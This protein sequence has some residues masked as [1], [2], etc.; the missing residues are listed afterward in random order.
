MLMI[1][2]AF[3]V[4]GED[5]FSQVLSELVL[6]DLTCSCS[7]MFIRFYF[8]FPHCL[9]VGLMFSYCG[10]FIFFLIFCTD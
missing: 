2:V 4:L 1:F 10:N 7:V 5:P 3:P 6:F 8:C 9:I